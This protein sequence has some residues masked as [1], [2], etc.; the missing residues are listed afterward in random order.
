MNANSAE[1][2][3]FHKDVK[4][5]TY[6]LGRGSRRLSHLKRRLEDHRKQN[7]GRDYY[8]AQRRRQKSHLMR[9][10]R[11]RDIKK[12]KKKKAESDSEYDDDEDSDYSYSYEDDVSSESEGND[13]NEEEAG[14]MTTKKGKGEDLKDGKATPCT[15]SQRHR[16]VKFHVN[17]WLGATCT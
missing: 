13:Y 15:A 4:S 9:P 16:S 1:S 6:I 11:V 8:D 17:C 10:E 3:S 12:E 14:D 7:R 2:F 5:D